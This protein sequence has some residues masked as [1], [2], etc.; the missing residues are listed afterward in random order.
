MSKAVKARFSTLVALVLLYLLFLLWQLPA[1]QL[2]GWLSSRL[3]PTLQLAGIQGRVWQ[4]SAA[5]AVIAG[6]PVTELRW[7]FKPWSL[8]TGKLAWQLNAAPSQSLSLGISLTG[9]IWLEQV[10]LKLDTNLLSSRL[11]LQGLN[12]SGLAQIQS[13]QLQWSSQGLKSLK[14]RLDW[15]QAAFKSPLAQAALGHLQLELAGDR[16]QGLTGKLKDIGGKLGVSGNLS[17]N[18]A[19]QFQF[20]GE[21]LALNQLPTD[22]ANMLRLIGQPLADGRLSFNQQLQLGWPGAVAVPAATASTAPAK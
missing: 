9:D 12:L 1:Q 10:Q 13:G 14:A 22:I 19:G 20:K 16:Q 4:G 6:V 2:Y 15:Q 3:A 17:L 21:S 11:P 7:Q 18:P 8:L 5:Q